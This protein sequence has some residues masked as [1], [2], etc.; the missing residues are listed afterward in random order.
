MPPPS[1][2]DY[3]QSSLWSTPLA[4]FQSSLQ[5]HIPGSGLLNLLLQPRAELYGSVNSASTHQVNSHNEA[6]EDTQV[7]V[8]T[9]ESEDLQRIKRLPRSFPGADTDLP[10]HSDILGGK[11]MLSHLR[12]VRNSGAAASPRS[13]ESRKKVLQSKVMKRQ[14]DPK[15]PI[16]SRNASKGRTAMTAQ[17]NRQ[18]QTFQNSAANLLATGVKN[19]IQ[20]TSVGS[21]FDHAITIDD[22]EDDDEINLHPN[23]QQAK[24]DGNTTITT[25]IE[26]ENAPLKIEPDRVDTGVIHPS[27]TLQNDWSFTKTAERD[28]SADH[29]SDLTPTKPTFTDLRPTFSKDSTTP[30]VMQEVGSKESPTKGPQLREGE[31]NLEVQTDRAGTFEQELEIIK[32]RHAKELHSLRQH[33]DTEL[34]KTK[35]LNNEMRKSVSQMEIDSR[36]KEKEDEDIIATLHHRLEAAEIEKNKLEATISENESVNALQQQIDALEAA[37]TKEKTEHEEL[38]KSL[39]TTRF[40]ARIESPSVKAASEQISTLQ[41]TNAVLVKEVEMLKDTKRSLLS[42]APSSS[43]QSSDEQNRIENVRKTYMKIKRNY[44]VLHSAAVKLNTCTNGMSFTNFGDF[45]S[46]LRQLRQVLDEHKNE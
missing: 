46:S 35:D 4:L 42:P 7:P 24:T 9:Q 17:R 16:G 1:L 32:L 21:S 29:D 44:D 33:Y 14:R 26:Y 23:P 43:S 6:I 31:M 13:S 39:D 41:A 38:M 15:K 25:S 22:E 27:S 28:S 18:L 11:D 34:Q 40:D 30:P 10:S 2:T 3:Q 19:S 8:P 45:G 36:R 12:M 20:E 37:L 5:Q